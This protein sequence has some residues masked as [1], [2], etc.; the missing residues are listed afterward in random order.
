LK[1][2]ISKLTRYDNSIW[3]PIRN[4]KQPK[5]NAPPIRKNNAEPW[6]KS[7]KEKADLFAEHLSTVYNPLNND[8]DP[9]ID[10]YLAH[11]STNQHPLTLTTPKEILGEITLLNPR[12]TPGA[13]L[14][15]AKMLKEPPRKGIVLL[16]Y[17]YNAIL[18]IG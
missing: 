17:I 15:T 4:L 8:S 14:I 12:K 13:D 10:H 6:A 9:H 11:P 5:H 18:R 3:K 16:P 7:D 1:N 2:I